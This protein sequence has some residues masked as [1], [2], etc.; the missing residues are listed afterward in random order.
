VVTSFD[1]GR[2]DELQRYVAGLAVKD[3]E[4]PRFELGSQFGTGDLREQNQRDIIVFDRDYGTNAEQVL[5]LSK[6]PPRRRAE[7]PPPIPRGWYARTATTINRLMLSWYAPASQ[8]AVRR[9]RDPAGHEFGT[10]T[11]LVMSQPRCVVAL[12]V[13]LAGMGQG[14]GSSGTQQ[15]PAD[16]RPDTDARAQRLNVG[17]APCGQ[18]RGRRQTRQ[19]AGD[20]DAGPVPIEQ[21]GNGKGMPE[22]VLRPTSA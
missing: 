12:A 5:S 20:V 21:R 19:P 7:A 15:P 14:C 16:K 13:V 18:V 6:L 9:R 17:G 11:D 8:R 22:V 3:G 2:D 1:A 10:P 4:L